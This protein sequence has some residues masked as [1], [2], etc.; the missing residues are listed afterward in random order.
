MFSDGNLIASK[1]K[2]FECDSGLQSISIH[3]IP[4]TLQDH[5]K[6]KFDIIHFDV[7]GPLAIQSLGKKRYFVTFI[8]E[9]RG[10]IRIYYVWHKSDL[11]MVFQM[12]Y[13]LVEIQ[14]SAKI[15]NL[16]TDNGGEFV[17][18]EM[19]TFLEIMAI[20][21]DL[22]QPYAYKSNSLPDCMNHTIVTMVQS[23]T[24]DCN[25]VISQVLW[26]EVYS[27]A[28]HIK[29]CLP[30]SAWKLKKPLYE[31]LSSDKASINHL[32]LFR[33]KCYVHVSE[34]PQ[35]GISKLSPR[36]ITSYVVS[37]TKSSKIL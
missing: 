13:N 34:E 16:K 11:K 32:Y 18:K 7:H 2:N 29:N 19:T 25:N 10:Y 37:Y 14:F 23:I 17:N 1:P 15:K 22:S 31:I 4:K 30:H 20:I 8:D 9:F 36:G 12:F 35:I 27:M 3:K 21:H 26:A 24:L 5:V 33:A 28:K 6:F